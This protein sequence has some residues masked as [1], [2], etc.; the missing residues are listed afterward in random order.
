VLVASLGVIG[1]RLT[2]PSAPAPL[3]TRFAAMLPEDQRF[4]ENGNRIIDVSPDGTHL[5]YV[6]NRRLYVRSIS[7]FE[8][9]PIAGTEISEGL[10]TGPMF[11]P[12]GQ[13]IAYWIG[14]GESGGTLKKISLSGGP[15]MTL[16]R[17][18]FPAGLSWSTAGIIAGLRDNTIVRIP[19]N[20]GPPELLA[21]VTDG[22][23]WGPQMLPGGDALLFTLTNVG[24]GFSVDDLNEARIVVQSLTSDERKTVLEAGSDARY[25]PT[26]HVIYFVGTTLFAVPFDLSRREAIGHGVPLVEDVSRR[27]FR[28]V[29]AYA[30]ISETGTLVYASG[31]APPLSVELIERTGRM[32]SLN[33]PPAVN[34]HLRISRDG[35]RLALERDDNNASN[36]WIADLTGASSIRQLTLTGRRNK[37]PI[38]SPDGQR[39]AFQSDRD[40]DAGI[41]WQHADGGGMAERLT[42]A[43]HGT[44]HVPQSWSPDGKTLLFTVTHLDGSFALNMLSRASGTIMSFGDVRSIRYTPGATFS[45]DGRWVAYTLGEGDANPVSGARVLVQ[46]FPPTGASYAISRGLH[47]MWSPDGKELFYHRLP[48]TQDHMEVVT[49]TSQSTQRNFTF[50]NPM[51]LPL[52]DMQFSRPEVERNWDIM[53]DGKRL[54]GLSSIIGARGQINVVLNWSEELKRLVP[55]K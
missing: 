6:A 39:V 24:A 52:R 11:S 54:V 47:P 4:T 1:G 34:L 29:G 51:S 42:K 55:T 38:W 26:G 35:T 48:D 31:A 7:D 50:S 27:P 45:P 25:I 2:S 46:P 21:T 28:G 22:N 41:F 10:I 49:V 20:G 36:I 12:D 3:V 53:P 17:L 33:V 23:V 30:A 19:S 8:A 43:D 13:S 37:Y 15:A 16:S 9:Q 40:G 14:S 44:T 18:G 5:V 32:T